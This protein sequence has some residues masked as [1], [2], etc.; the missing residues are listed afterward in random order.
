MAGQRAPHVPELAYSFVVDSDGALGYQ[1]YLLA[2]SLM[3]F[4]KVAPSQITAHLVEGTHPSVERT[5]RNLGVHTRSVKPFGHPYCNK[6]QQLESL[7]TN[8]SDGVVLLD[9]DTFAL[10]PLTFPGGDAILGKMVDAPLPPIEIVAALFAEAGLPL[11]PDEADVIAGPT[12]RANFNGG[13]Y[14]IPTSFIGLL[15]PAWTRWARWC[16]ERPEAFGDWE[17]NIDQLSFALAIAELSLPVQ[18]LPRKYNA[19]THL[20]AHPAPESPLLLHY[21]R[22]VDSQLL[23]L[24]TGEATIDRAIDMA[25]AAIV[26]WRNDELPNHLFWSARY[27]LN[28]ELGSGVGSRGVLLER[29]RAVLARLLPVL[30]AESLI[31]IGGG[32]GAVMEGLASELTHRAVDISPGAAVEYLRRNPAAA[33]EIFDITTGRAPEAD[34]AISLDLLPHISDPEAYRAAVR[35]ILA[36]GR[37]AA[38]V[39]GYDDEPAWRSSIVYFHEPLLSTVTNEVERAAFPVLAYR[40]LVLYVVLMESSTGHPR[41]ARPDVLQRAMPITPD[42]AALLECVV[43]SRRELGFF[44]KHLP[45]CI[46]YPWLLKRVRALER[47]GLQIVDVGAGVNVLPILLH[48]DGHCLTTIDSHPVTRA[49]AERSGWNEWGFLDYGALREG[50]CSIRAPYEQADLPLGC[51]V[52]YSISVIEHLK[53]DMRREWIARMASQIRSGGKLFLTVDIQPLSRD[54][55]PFSEGTMVEGPDQHG[56]LDDLLDELESGGFSIDG[57]TVADWLPMCRVGVALV[58]AGRR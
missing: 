34:V 8:E 28:P 23:L 22:H 35:N 17:R 47:T 18:K 3:T 45:R 48:D 6:I 58:E 21:H 57:A 36:S 44:P 1:S 56:S 49:G 38:F 53:A 40:G 55:W 39:S 2:R 14:V 25:N 46:E 52:V 54:L 29:K 15:Y 7:R 32:D 41:D 30:E 13:L 43:V 50:I 12:V 27:R 16:L 31:D 20:G 4:G 24:P 37:I 19:P 9:A 11:E 51:D 10:A 26:Q 33:F 5:L 42:A